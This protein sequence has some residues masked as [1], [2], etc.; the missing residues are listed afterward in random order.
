MAQKYC[1]LQETSVAAVPEGMPQPCQLW[2]KG[3]VL[4]SAVDLTSILPCSSAA[5]FVLV[6]LN[7]MPEYSNAA[8][9]FVAQLWH[10]HMH[11]QM[12]VLLMHA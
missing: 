11:G 3:L 6:A 8:H 5:A 4:G 12:P 9:A 2:P 10:S 7:C 1:C